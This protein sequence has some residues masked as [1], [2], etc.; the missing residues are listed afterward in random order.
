MFL[1]LMQAESLKVWNNRGPLFFLIGLFP[2]I[3]IVFILFFLLVV[4]LSSEAR[5]GL[6]E[7]NILWTQTML[8]MW[9]IPNSVLG[10]AV[11]LAFVAMQFGGEYQWNTLK[12]IVPRSRRA[13]IILAKFLTLSLFILAAFVLLTLI[14][15]GGMRLITWVG[16]VPYGP[17]VTDVVIREFSE[18][19]VVQASTNIASTII[20]IGY[21]AMAAMLTRSVLGSVMVSFVLATAEGLS[22]LAFVLVAFFLDRQW[23]Y[24]L[25]RYTPTFNIINVQAWINDNEGIPLEWDE[26]IIGYNTLEGSIAILAIWMV[27]LI[28]LTLILFQRQD[29]TN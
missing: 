10:R 7:D 21:A 17:A 11:I 28:A 20:A 26:Q 23:I 27:F 5:E 1:K 6:A 16:D 14:A 12:N 25:Y 4:T 15:G 24:E 8:S 2:M 22:V 18:D 19:Y 3:G 13:M 9:N 29:I